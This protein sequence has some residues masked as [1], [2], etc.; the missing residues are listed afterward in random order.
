MTTHSER[1]MANNHEL[2][3]VS[4]SVAGDTLNPE[5]WTEY[6][7][8]DPDFTVVKG[9]RFKTPSGRLSSAPGR[10]GVWIVRSNK[11]VRSDSLEPHFRYL[12]QHLKFPRAN[13]REHLEKANVHMRFFCYWSNERGDRVPD[14]PDDIRAMMES[15]GGTVEIDEYR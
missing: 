1:D 8:V 15:M 9:Q 10:T 4:F 7:S 6:F 5:F 14:V 3:Y 12:V 11:A 13:L 2:A